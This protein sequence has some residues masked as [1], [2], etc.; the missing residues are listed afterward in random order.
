MDRV[1]TLAPE[2]SVKPTPRVLFITG[3]YPPRIG[4]VGDHVVRLAAAIEARGSA[5]HVATESRSAS[6]PIARVHAVGSRL[7]LQAVV[8]TLRV[9]RRVRPDVI[10]LHYQ[11]GAFARPG[12]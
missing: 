4:G 10:H 3:E 5:C 1:A 2:A 8:D 7:P 6:D 12:S 11:A 9:V